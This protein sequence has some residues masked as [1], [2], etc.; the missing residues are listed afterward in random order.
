MALCQE[1]E[2][3]SCFTVV[4]Q[5][6]VIDWSCTAVICVSEMMIA[7]MVSVRWAVIIVPLG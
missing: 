2:V 6:R 4:V 3:V 7:E 5:V 1:I